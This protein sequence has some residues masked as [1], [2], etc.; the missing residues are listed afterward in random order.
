MYILLLSCFISFLNGWGRILTDGIYRKIYISNMLY[1]VASA[2]CH[3]YLLRIPKCTSFN[4]GGKSAF[5]LFIIQLSCCREKL[6][7][8]ICDSL[9]VIYQVQSS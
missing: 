1:L 4:V 9:T 2:F 5:L 3:I 7:I 8:A 6:K